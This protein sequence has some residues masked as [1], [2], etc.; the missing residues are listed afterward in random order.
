MGTR[1]RARIVRLALA[2]AVAAVALA[3]AAALP[4]AAAQ[5]VITSSEVAY[6]FVVGDL[7]DPGDKLVL[8]VGHTDAVAPVL[9]D[10]ELVIKTKDDTQLHAPGIVYRD[11]EDLIFHV[12]PGAEIAAPGFAPYEFL[13]AAGD[14]AWVLP[15]TQDPSLLWP[16]WS[17]E[18]ASLAGQFGGGIRYEITDV[19]GPG[20]FFLFL[21][22]PFGGPIHRANSIGTLSNVWTEPVPAHVHANWA[23]T[24][25]G[26]YTI[27]FQVQGT[28]L[29][30]PDPVETTLSITGAE[31]HV[32]PGDA[33]TLTAVQDPPTGEDHYHWFVRPAGESE[34]TVVPG[35]LEGTYTF[36]AQAEH[37]GA[38]YMV[39]LYDHDHEVIAESPPVTIEVDDHGEPGPA[40]PSVEL[41]VNGTVGT[42][43]GL[44]LDEAQ[45]GLGTFLPGVAADY[46]ATVSG[47]VT[48]TGPAVLS[49]SDGGP[50]AGFLLNGS[51]PLAS[52]LRLCATSAASPAC[53]FAALGAG[54]LPLLD[55]ASSTSAEPI[56]VG[57]RQSVLASEPLSAGTYGK[58]LTFTLSA[59]TP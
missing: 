44:V 18:H 13:G 32:H 4:A 17:T 26:T 55:V 14:P 3:A 35:A 46:D 47:S 50:S 28:W 11:P 53:A 29:N 40:E 59:G 52:P 2:A 22:D 8:D 1:S 39:R 23:F 16:G 49:V 31:G 6:T 51:T 36:T 38:Q 12:K 5:Q 37:D 30:A 41:G 34:F 25:P 9:E 56:T 19:E 33:V 57:V 54:P 42:E 24:A 15:M 27:T 20:N 58:T 21:N 7:G 45:V 43:L 48:S 10:G